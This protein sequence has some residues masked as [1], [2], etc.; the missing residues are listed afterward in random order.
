M[1]NS[2]GTYDTPSNGLQR[3]NYSPNFKYLEK[4]CLRIETRL[5]NEIKKLDVDKADEKEFKMVQSALEDTKKIAE[6]A[7]RAA[8]IP[9]GCKYEERLGKLEN[10]LS[11][12]YVCVEK[13]TIEK[14]ESD[15]MS[16]RK[17]KLATWL[18][19]IVA[20]ATSSLFLGSMNT[21]LATTK[22]DVKEIK[23]RVG[24]NT[25]NLSKLKNSVERNRI[26]DR[27]TD[28]KNIR[29]IETA[30][31]EAVQKVALNKRRK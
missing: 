18:T 4:E 24:E 5:E 25:E 8:S 3:L 12:P 15:M 1:K 22:D 6:E 2:S 26:E 7:R 19:I 11:T 30:I 28:E 16:R 21:S 20:I 29:R 31:E 14:L 23:A 9:Y 27:A 17:Y 10:R 13:E